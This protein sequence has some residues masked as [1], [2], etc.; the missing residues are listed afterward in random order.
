MRSE[1]W[2][3]LPVAFLSSMLSGILGMGGGVL[4]VATMATTLPPGA[5]VAVHGVVQLVSNSTRTLQL[6]PHVRWRIALLY[7][8]GLVL[9][10]LATLPLYRDTELPWF[11]PLIGAFV[12][13]FL[14]WD[15]W[16]PKRLVLPLWVFF[17]AG[18]ASGVVTLLVGASGPFLAAFFLRDDLDRREVIATKAFL[19]TFGH[20][21]KIP[22]FLSLGFDYVGEAAL[23][24]PLLAAVVAGT[25]AGNWVLDRMSETLFRK[26]FRWVLLALGVRL[27][28]SPWV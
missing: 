9:G 6:L 28:V 10:V 14:A 25:I 7:V 2:I 21:A 5:V 8:P 27:L 17:P 22:A 1:L 16:R 3:L 24:L 20:A 12:L 23:I 19:Q 26:A 11:K 15:Q 18:I 13:A 4:L